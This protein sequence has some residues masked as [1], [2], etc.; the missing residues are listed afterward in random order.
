MPFPNLIPWKSKER[1]LT[2]RGESQD[3]FSQLQQEMDRLFE[4]FRGF[5]LAPMGSMGET[6]LAWAPAVNV[7]EDEKAIHVTAELPGMDE[8]DIDVDLSGNVLTIRGEK[9]EE[10]KQEDRNF[11]RMERRYGSFQRQIELPREVESDKVDASF[12][13]GVLTIHLPKTREAQKDVRKIT[14]KT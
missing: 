4:E 9:K 10:E 12:K 1:P 3:P 6:G 14:V 2:R 8:K 5:G 13:K 11:Y 7:A